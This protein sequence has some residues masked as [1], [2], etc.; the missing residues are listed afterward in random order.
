MS[1]DID[2]RSH[3]MKFLK[4]AV[5]SILSVT[6]VISIVVLIFCNFTALGYRMTVSFHG[7]KEISNN[8]YVDENY[9]GDTSIFLERIDKAK[10]RVEKFFGNTESSPIIIISGS[11]EKLSRLGGDHDTKTIAFNGSKSYIS[12]SVNYTDT[13]IIAHELTHSEVHYR[14]LKGKF[15]INTNLPVW[16]DEGLAMQNDCRKEFDDSQWEALTRNSENLE[17]ISQYTT[18]EAFYN[19]DNEITTEHYILARHTVKDWIEQNGKDKLFSILT[20]LNSGKAFD[21]VFC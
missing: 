2:K 7:F 4:I 6:T 3:K 21:D 20:D 10:S 19:Q 12:L 15:F 11:K 1:G 5:I 13:D 14:I 8:I 9:A 17:D 18:P 16:F